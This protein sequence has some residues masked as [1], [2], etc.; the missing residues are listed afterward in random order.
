MSLCIVYVSR[1]FVD[2]L[3]QLRPADPDRRRSDPHVAQFLFAYIPA[4]CVGVQLQF[5]SYLLNCE[6]FIFCQ[7]YTIPLLK[8]PRLYNLAQLWS[9]DDT[10]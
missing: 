1:P 2:K 8:F 9:T 3:I 4:Y 7:E 5:F 6:Q 10:S